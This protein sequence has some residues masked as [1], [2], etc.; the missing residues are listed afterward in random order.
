MDLRWGVIGYGA[1]GTHHARAIVETPGAKLF[2][3]ATPSEES[4]EKARKDFPGIAVF[5]DYRDLL[6]CPELEAL[7]IV[8]PTDLHEEIAVAS[9]EAGKHVLLEKP[10]AL[11]EKGCD[12]ILEAARRS[13]KTLNVAHEFR[14]SIQWGAIKKY[15]DEGRMG[16]PLYLLINLWRRPYRPG[17][18]GWRRNFHRVG[19]W[20]MEEPIHFFDLALWY[21]QVLGDPIAIFAQANSRMRAEGFYD[22]FSAGIR[23]GSGAYAVLSQTL[24]GFEHHKSVEFVGTKGAVRAWWSGPMDRASEASYGMKMIE[25]LKG[26]ESFDECIPTEVPLEGKSGEV[27]ELRELMKKIILSIRD[28][29]PLVSGEEGRKAVLLCRQAEEALRAGKEIPLRL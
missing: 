11:D 9:L 25:G 23:W 1:W 24:G 22:N 5:A 15:I 13:G 29:K 14:F 2:G 17:R 19:S 3:V 4:Q 10:M 21:F 18:E 7:S 27:Y 8:T 20:I 6:R 16:E 28:G 26:G 12:R